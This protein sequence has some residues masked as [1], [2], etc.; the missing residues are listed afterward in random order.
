LLGIIYYTNLA[1]KKRLVVM[2]LWEWFVRFY[3]PTSVNEGNGVWIPA[4][5]PVGRQV[6]QIYTDIF[7]LL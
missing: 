4:D 1:N 3:D 7:S 6:T 5:Q 2:E